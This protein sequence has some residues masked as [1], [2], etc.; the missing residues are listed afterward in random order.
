MD[1]KKEF[2]NLL[3]DYIDFPVDEINTEESFKSVSGVDSFM[4][5]EL[6]SSIEDKF[7]IAIPNSDL[8]HFKSVNDIVG[9]I[10]KRIS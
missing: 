4:L 7:K 3:Q 10:G 9:Y 5:I 8:A 2:L 6:I 1:V